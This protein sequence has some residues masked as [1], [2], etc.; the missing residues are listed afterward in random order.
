MLLQT[1]QPVARDTTINL[2]WHSNACPCLALQVVTVGTRQQKAVVAV[3][4]C[5]P[6]MRL[7]KEICTSFIKRCCLIYDPFAN[8]TA[9]GT[10]ATVTMGR[11]LEHCEALVHIVCEERYCFGQY[12][13]ETQRSVLI[14]ST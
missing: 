12:A 13:G 8:N 1:K 10:D 7:P 6:Q 2:I 4:H 9:W 3:T 14:I 11:F 5:N